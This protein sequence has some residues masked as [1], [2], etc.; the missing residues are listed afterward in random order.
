VKG[1]EGRLESV[2]EDVTIIAPPEAHIEEEGEDGGALPPID[3]E[4][5]GNSSGYSL[6]SPPRRPKQ[7]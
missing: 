2:T 4:L 3:L 5:A 1:G 6:R 7:Q